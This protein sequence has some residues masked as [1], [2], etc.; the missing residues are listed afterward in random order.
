MPVTVLGVHRVDAEASVPHQPAAARREQA[1]RIAS[2][3][4]AT[5]PTPS[6]GG[7]GFIAERSSNMCSVLS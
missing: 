1:S 2:S 6:R 7:Y 3:S 4:G 5:L